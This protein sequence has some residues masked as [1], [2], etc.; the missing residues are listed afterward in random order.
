MR[1]EGKHLRGREF[2]ITPAV[3]YQPAPASYTVNDHGE[4]FEAIQ[5]GPH[6]GGDTGY[7]LAATNTSF[8]YLWSR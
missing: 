4:Y 2:L 3:C 1:V 6:D 5:Y 8:F 7:L